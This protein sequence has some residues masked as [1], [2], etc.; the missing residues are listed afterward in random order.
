MARGPVL[1]C[2]AAGAALAL[3]ACGADEREEPS[4][5]PPAAAADA[6]AA[7]D[8][9]SGAQ[10]DAEARRPVL[11]LPESG[12]PVI[13]P[14]PKERVVLRDRPGGKVIAR[15]GQETEW[16]SPTVLYVAERR[17]AWAGVPTPHRENGELAWVRLDATKLVAG[18]V[19]WE[20]R[21]DLSDFRAE[22]RRD[23]KVVR[24]FAVTVGAPESSTPTGRF[25][26]TDTFRGGLDPSYGCCAV[27]LTARQPDLPSGWMGGDRI[28]I[29][30]TDGPLGRA[31]SHGCVRAR[32]AD[33]NALV[34]RVPPGTPVT[35]TQ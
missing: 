2:L 21:V 35:I 17:G 32:D 3:V 20:I 4:A 30:G 26:V 22:L 16:G 29:H 14:R 10:G 1:A 34:E 8:S 6:R 9:G 12:H 31:A 5:A 15:L 7:A 11:E 13:W 28:A 19:P 18:S 24:S 25:A 27:A 33:V 23:G